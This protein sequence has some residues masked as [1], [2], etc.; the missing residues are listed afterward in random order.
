MDGHLLDEQALG[1]GL[2]LPFGFQ[3]GVELGK[4][5]G[6]LEGEDGAAG[7]QTVLEG[8]QADGLFTLGSLGTGGLLRIAQVGFLLYGG[9]QHGIYLSP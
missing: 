4:R 3:A 5:V 8:V 2:R 1:G 6:V 9:N 7:A